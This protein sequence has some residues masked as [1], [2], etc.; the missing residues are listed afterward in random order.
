MHTFNIN[1]LLNVY[2]FEFNDFL[3]P[4]T[5]NVMALGHRPVFVI[6]AVIGSKDGWKLGTIF[7]L[8]GV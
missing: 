6:R 7:K 2:W 4:L 5:E 1:V 8:K 3:G